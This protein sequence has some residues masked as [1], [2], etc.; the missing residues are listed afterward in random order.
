MKNF[1]LR[2]QRGSS[3]D[4]QP[5]VPRCMGG[6]KNLPAAHQ[7]T[8]LPK[9]F[10]CRAERAR[11]PISV[12]G[13]QM[14]MIF[15]IWLAAH[16]CTRFQKIFACGASRALAPVFSLQ[17]LYACF[18][19]RARRSNEPES[20]KKKI[21]CGAEKARFLISLCRVRMRTIF[22]NR[23]RRTP[24]AR[25]QSRTPEYHVFRQKHSKPAEKT[26][27]PKRPNR[28]HFDDF[29]FDDFEFYF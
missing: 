26:I 5:A 18:L 10:A 4:L 12:C 17:R 24:K 7:C 21:A 13:A 23:L 6:R 19:E 8:E 11:F 16:W 20:Q 14:R 3:S 27:Q 29:H 2:R 15:D 9:N 25:T 22:E 28:F 1:R